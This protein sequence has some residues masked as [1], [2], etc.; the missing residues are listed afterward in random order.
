[1][2]VKT[3]S[4]E[5][6]TS[7]PHYPQSNGKAENAVQTVKCLFKKCRKSGQSE[8]LALLDWRN[9]PTEG[10]G[11]SP[12]Q[13]LMGRRC[14]T[15]LP[16][17]ATLLQPRYS[18]EE[19]TRALV[20]MKQ[21]QQYYYNKHTK[22]LK[23]ISPGETVRMKL[24]GQSNWSAGTCTGLAGLR[25]YNVK[26]GHIYRRNRRQLIHAN[27]LPIL[28]MQDIIEPSPPQS[29]DSTAPS[30]LLSPQPAPSAEPSQPPLSPGSTALRGPR[31]SGRT[32]KPPAWLRDYVPA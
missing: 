25:S 3:W 13:R 18:T 6:V 31:R 12:A 16:V 17:A 11:T 24:P 15:L 20:G 14:K 27:E 30:I 5:H 1:M 4:F 7:S 21:R 28:D 9:T 29:R 2:F 10:V 8:F 26:V 23:P 32:H 19:D 22:S